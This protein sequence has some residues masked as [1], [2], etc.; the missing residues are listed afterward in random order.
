MLRPRSTARN[1]TI[2]LAVGLAA[3]VSALPGQATES[4]PG[5]DVNAVGTPFSG[6]APDGTARGLLDAHSHIFANVSFGGGL[7]CG[8]PFDPEGPH[9]ALVDCPDHFPDGSAA[10][11]ENFTKTGSPTGTHDPVGYPTF[12][13]WPAHNS[14]THQQ[15][16][17]KWIERAWRG[18][19][20]FMVN[21]LVANRQLC[22]IY[23]IKNQSCNEMD[24]IRLQA[25]LTTDLQNF[26]DAESG[27]PGKGWFRVVRSQGEARQV[28]EQGK[29]AVML[30]IETSE[31]FG[32]RHILNV[33]QCS[34]ADI[35]RG[36]DEVHA[37]GVRTMFVCHKYDNALCGV[38]FD[39]GTAG[40]AVN[41]AN[42]L[43][44]GTFWDART[45]TTAYTDNTL[46]A[47]GTVPDILKPV[48]PLPLYPPA[49]HCNT[50]G[51]TDLGEYMIKGMM[52]REM[53]VELDH[54]SVKAA[55]R[56]LDLLEEA[57]YPGVIS[58]HSWTD[59]KYFPRIYKLGGMIAQYGHSA[60][61]FVAEWQR[62]EGY[63]DQNG[64]DG[65]GFG[66]DVN[67]V[68]GLPAPRAG[69]VSYPFKSADGSVTLDRETMAQRTW[70]YTK[71]GMAHYGLMP[72][73]VEDLRKLGGEEVVQDLLGGAEAYLRTWRAV[74]AYQPKVNLAR[75]AATTASSYEWNPFWD[76]R[77]PR[78][79]DGD[80]GSRWAS[81]WSD[82]QWLRVDL[83]TKKQVSRV[84]VHWEAAYA[85]AW[86]VEVS[87][88]LSSW[89]PVGR[90]D[91]GQGGLDVVSFPPVEARYVTI[92]GERRATNY[93][94]SAYEY[95]VF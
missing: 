54:M 60:A 20:R 80:R 27:G 69:G 62:G 93:G 12:K 5:A 85:S 57:A 73:W 6:T 67:G 38:R 47:A 90:V 68:G 76:F 26:I 49:P 55:D 84:A 66:I 56:A 58:S 44:T 7:I 3:V 94:F 46:A 24:S 52:A 91:G 41:A 89:R 36:L 28:V 48:V 95:E 77:A 83:G 92:V 22:D 25:K 81:G 17:Y 32:C 4:P 9:K 14:L 8:K 59:E 15:A 13:D 82:G 42:F 43:G 31:P 79:T 16:Y 1:L 87:D 86:R 19:L 2:L 18:G 40:L 63:R 50:R 72:D 30:G 75:G 35:D 64:I 78:A 53:M 45:C 70:D 21:H 51:L 88:D 65:Y 34:K 37:L 33:A 71:D 74:E 23:P 39:S 11:F 29:L 61:Q 10:W